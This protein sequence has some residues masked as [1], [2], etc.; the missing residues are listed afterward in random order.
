ML[1]RLSYISLFTLAMSC[2]AAPPASKL[3]PDTAPPEPEERAAEKDRADEVEADDSLDDDAT[4]RS[5]SEK[6]GSV[7]SKP[8]GD[9]CTSEKC[10]QHCGELTGEERTACAAA[11][12]HGCF[13]SSPDENFACGEHQPGAKE[14]LLT[15]P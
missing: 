10:L 15:D 4:D 6:D 3:Q 2:A 12:K 8:A 7:P 5:L 1:K 11:W 13:T 14:V 9:T